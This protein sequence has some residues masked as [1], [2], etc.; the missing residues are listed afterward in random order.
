[1]KAKKSK[2]K[3]ATKRA[4]NNLP[5]K[6]VRGVKGGYEGSPVATYSI[7]NAWPMKYR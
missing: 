1:M 3:P 6:N 4:A 7:Q 2:S 5:L